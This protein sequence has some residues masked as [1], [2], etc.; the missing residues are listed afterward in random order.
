VTRRVASAF[1]A[2]KIKP[3][4]YSLAIRAVSHELDNP[5]RIEISGESPSAVRLTLRKTADLASQL[6]NGEWL[7]SMPGTDAEKSQLLNCVGCH[8][9]ERIARSPYNK[10]RC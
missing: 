3:G 9:L 10:L 2:S 7:V 1:S 8:T 5:T 4:E 6:S